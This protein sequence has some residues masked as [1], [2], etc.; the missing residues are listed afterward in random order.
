MSG[1]GGGISRKTD[2][3]G[4]ASDLDGV[5]SAQVVAQTSLNDAAINLADTEEHAHFTELHFH[6]IERWL[7]FGAVDTLTPYQ[8]IS[9]AGDYGADPGDEAII[10]TDEQTPII[11]EKI[12]FDFHRIMV[13]DVTQDTHFK[14]RIV[15]GT[16]TMA[17]AISAG[18]YTEFMAKHD[19]ANP[20]E[21]ATIPIAI[22]MPKL[23]AGTK[24]WI[25]TKNVTDNAAIDFFVGIHEYDAV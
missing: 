13:V 6:S 5:A 20:Q 7:G 19:S 8:A 23:A 3:S 24:V 10:L 22:M 21:S 11:A 16:G 25:Q 15:Y 4:L 2:L 18:Q 14:L 17:E 12:S 9:G 1:T